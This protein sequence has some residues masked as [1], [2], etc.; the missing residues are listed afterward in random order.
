VADV[1][2]GAGVGAGAATG[3][4][5][6]RLRTFGEGFAV[7]VTNPK[8]LVFFAAVLPQF[9]DRGHGHAAAQMLLLG[10]VFNLIALVS[11]SVWGMTAAGARDWFARS[12][13][14]L[15]MVGGAGGLSMIGLGVAIAVTGNKD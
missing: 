8:T 6:G 13:R 4:A 3:A 10:L 12:P 2:A 14:R 15:S 9:V 1:G 7:G 11:D 5:H